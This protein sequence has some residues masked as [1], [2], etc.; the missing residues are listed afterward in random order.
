MS[1]VDPTAGQSERC[2]VFDIRYVNYLINWGAQLPKLGILASTSR[3]GAPSAG[4]VT[5]PALEDSVPDSRPNSYRRSGSVPAARHSVP[6][7]KPS[8]ITTGTAAASILHR[9]YRRHSMIFSMVLLK[10]GKRIAGRRMRL[11]GYMP[12]CAAA[13]SHVPIG[14]YPTVRNMS[15]NRGSSSP[16]LEAVG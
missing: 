5:V 16:A 2:T 1:P 11:P 8:C 6:C 12:Q 3:S 10:P 15:S 13:A 14:T 9:N 4:R 7:R